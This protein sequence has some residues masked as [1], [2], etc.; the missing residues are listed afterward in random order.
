MSE[1]AADN[2][3][4]YERGDGISPMDALSIQKYD[5]KLISKLPESIKA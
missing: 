1:E 4:V 5:A 2:A 3:D